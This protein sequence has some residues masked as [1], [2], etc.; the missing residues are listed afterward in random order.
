MTVQPFHASMHSPGF[1]VDT[2]SSQIFL[3]NRMARHLSRY[4]LDKYDAN[5]YKTRQNSPKL[6]KTRQIAISEFL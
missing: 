1:L 2:G 6:A 5:A 4:N 3:K